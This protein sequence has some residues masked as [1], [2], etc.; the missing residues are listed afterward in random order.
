MT[1]RLWRS[2]PQALIAIAT[3]IARSAR[4]SVIARIADKEVLSSLVGISTKLRPV[5]VSLVYTMLPTEWMGLWDWMVQISK[6]VPTWDRGG[7]PDP[8]GHLLLVELTLVD[9]HPS[10]IRVLTGTVGLGS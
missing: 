8:F 9:V 7:L 3:T 2:L 4:A 6:P 1:A 5:A 10:G